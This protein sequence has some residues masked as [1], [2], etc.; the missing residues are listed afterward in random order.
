MFDHVLLTLTLLFFAGVGLYAMTPDER[1]RLFQATVRILRHVKEAATRSDPDDER[2]RAAL[3]ART[4]WVVLTPALVA[5]NAGLFACMLFGAGRLSDAQTLVTWGANLG[6]KTTNGEW[7]RL[8]TSMFVH[9]GL[10]PMLVNMGVMWYAGPALE[11]LVGRFL[12]VSVYVGAGILASLVAVVAYPVDVNIGASGAVCG[13]AGL[14]TASWV[15]GVRRASEMRVPA[16]A[17]KRLGLIGAA[18]LVYTFANGDLPLAGELTAL[19]VGLVSGMVLTKRVHL[20]TPPARRVAAVMAGTAALAVMIGVPLEGLTDIRP[21]IAR[22]VI[23]EDG[24]TAA[25]TNA[26]ER[27]KKGRLAAE[28][29]VELIGRTIVPQLEAAEAHFNT[30]DRV[31]S[32]HQPLLADAREYLRLRTE[33]WRLRAEGLRKAPGAAGRETAAS[34]SPESSAA[35]RARAQARHRANMNTFGR[36]EGMERVSLA[37]LARI[38]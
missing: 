12:F 3:R 35:A 20:A 13:L 11:R 30:F 1:G 32:I 38:R 34:N 18:F 6:T 24:T 19:G 31:P 17:A 28:A 2:F 14:L 33:S 25:Y 22:L 23:L 26:V 9:A 4:R 15:W 29:L 16:I 5:V 36:A 37:A 10:L 8:G 7:W 21:E 27:F